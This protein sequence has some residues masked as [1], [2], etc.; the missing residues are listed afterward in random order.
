MGAGVGAKNADPNV[1]VVIGGLASA[2]IGSD[3]IKGMVDWCKEFRGYKPDGTVNLCWDVINY[4]M[5]SD[6][7]SSSQSGNSTRGAAPEVTPIDRIAKDF[8]QTAHNQSYDMPVWVT[9]AGYDVHQGSPLRAIPIGNKSA[10]E[11][12]GDWVLRTALFYARQGIEKVYFYQLYDDNQTGGMFGTSGLANGDNLTRRPAAD[13]LYQTNKLFGEYSYKETL[14]GN[15]IV[16]RYEMNGKSA[17]ML[18]VPDE[19]GRTA[20]YTLDLGGAA[21]AQIYRPKTGAN[22]MDL[23]VVNTT[24]GQLQVTVTE[25]PMF[26]VA[27]SAAPNARV[28]ANL[29]TEL[30]SLENSVS[31]YP[32]PTTDIITIQVDRSS[33]SSIHVNLFD[34]GTGR[35]HRQVKISKTGSQF[36]SNIDVTHLPVGTYILE[37]KQD[38]ERVMKKVLKSN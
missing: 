29:V 35:I 9:E 8:R 7:T 16:D 17:Y 15:P 11:T 22:N 27:G 3:Y 19:V 31:V 37:I 21:Q 20:T 5:Y 4:H 30:Q 32:N 24:N 28:A 2:S 13:Y 38:D 34:A 10:L 14:I 18:V 33:N 36:S 12:Q 1:K 6:N 26:V 23:E 25:T